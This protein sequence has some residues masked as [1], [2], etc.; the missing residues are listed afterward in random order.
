MADSLPVILG[1]AYY[2]RTTASVKEKR[3]LRET[4]TLAAM[5]AILA[6][7]RRIHGQKVWQ[8]FNSSDTIGSRTC[9]TAV[10]LPAED[11]AEFTP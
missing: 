11:K 10:L 4:R 1:A 6:T 8:T 5:K 7:R 2:T 3:I 9:V